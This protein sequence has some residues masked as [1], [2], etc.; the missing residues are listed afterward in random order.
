MSNDGRGFSKAVQDSL[1]FSLFGEV[2]PNR[3]APPPLAVDHRTIA[4]RA[5]K[6]YIAELIFLIPTAKAPDGTWTTTQF[7]IPRDNIHI[8]I[9]EAGQEVRFPSIVMLGEEEGTYETLGLNNYWDESTYG[10]YGKG[11]VVQ[12]QDTYLENITLEIWASTRPQLWSLLSGLETALTPT[13]TR[14][15]V[16]FKLKDY[17]NQICSF[18]PVSRRLLEDAGEAMLNR[19]LGHVKVELRVNRVALV[20]ARTIEPVVEINVD[21]EECACDPGDETP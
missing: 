6:A 9:P 7:K 19:R 18:T 5:L 20:N 1:P 3:P 15:G 8:S 11:T 17:F 4:L 14:Y 2:F 13:E 16:Y 10:V 21:A 12:W